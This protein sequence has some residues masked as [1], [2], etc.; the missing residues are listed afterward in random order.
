IRKRDRFLWIHGHKDIV[1]SVGINGFGSNYRHRNGFRNQGPTGS[2]V[3]MVREAIALHFTELLIA[4]GCS[5]G[6]IVEFHN[7]ILD[8]SHLLRTLY[9]HFIGLT[10]WLSTVGSNLPTDFHNKAFDFLRS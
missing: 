2:R 8:I 9:Q 10:I 6:S 1:V 4:T 3:H 7:K 5:D